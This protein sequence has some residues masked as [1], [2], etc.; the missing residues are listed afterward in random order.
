MT[1]TTNFSIQNRNHNHTS[2]KYMNLTPH[3][4]QRGMERLNITNTDELKKMA[5]SARFKGIDIDLL[6]IRNYEQ[7][8]ITY[9][10]L[11]ILKKKYYRHN[12]SE[13]LFYYKNFV[14][15]FCGANALTIRS[16]V[17][18]REDRK[19]SNNNINSNNNTNTN[20]IN[21]KDVVIA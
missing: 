13:R 4:K 7:L 14:W 11:V 6:N 15:V 2:W 12:N 3:S 10:E 16:V 8:G 19:N 20:N 5:N 18:F 9:D 17:P 21:Y 1:H